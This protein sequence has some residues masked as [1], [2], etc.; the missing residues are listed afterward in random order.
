[1]YKEI[2]IRTAKNDYKV[3]LQNGFFAVNSPKPRIHK[4]NYAELH[5]I[6]GGEA[7]FNIAGK[8]I[9]VKSGD[10]IMIP[11]R[12]LHCIVEC[13]PDVR[14]SAF[15]IACDNASIATH[16]VSTALLAEFFHEIELFKKSE[17]YSR[18]SA[19][20]ILFISCFSIEEPCL[21][22]EIEDPGFLIHEFFSQS[23]GDDVRLSD[24]A[25]ILHLSV[26][27]TERLVLEYTGHTFG[28]E[29]AVTRTDAA[30]Y[31]IEN[32]EL[33]LTEIAEYVGYRSYAGFWKAMKKRKQ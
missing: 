31:L 25:S 19:Y 16:T 22:S 20:I 7:E 27:Q 14:H 24:L 32:T 12:T 8:K 29:L 17:D 23:Y 11:R 2:T 4:H 18:I 28:D 21:P 13:S 9:F 10:I 6:L 33:S 1:M 15:Q 5:L 30:V 26:R 3:F